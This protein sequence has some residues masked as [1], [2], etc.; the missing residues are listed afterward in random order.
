MPDLL[1]VMSGGAIGAG[2]RFGIGQLVAIGQL[3]R[4]PAFPWATLTV[5]LTGALLMGLLTGALQR[6]N[7]LGGSAWLFLGVGV[8][9]GFTTFSAFSLDAVT[10]MGRGAYGAALAYVATSV[11][12]ALALFA[13]GLVLTK[14]AG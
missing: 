11:L 8:L 14:A 10:L 2:A 3:A 1:F 12:G 5:N 13:G 4:G 7:A 6:Q 9:G